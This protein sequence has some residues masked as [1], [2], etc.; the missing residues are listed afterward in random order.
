M[1]VSPFLISGLETKKSP[2]DLKDRLGV[3]VVCGGVDTA[4][5]MLLRGGFHLLS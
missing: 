1:G 4:C 2:A 3:V 5:L